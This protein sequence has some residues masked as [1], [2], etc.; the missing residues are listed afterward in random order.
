MEIK[1]ETLL[2]IVTNSSSVTYVIAV[3]SGVEKIKEL[4]NELAKSFGADKSFDDLF[5][6]KI[7]Y[8]WYDYN[9]DEDV[10]KDSLDD[11]ADEYGDNHYTSSFVVTAKDEKDKKA[12]QILSTLESMFSYDSYY[13]G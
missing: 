2:D 8:E 6:I 11:F 12:A 7:M 3:K 4:V 9:T 5:D 13:D 1:L 10:V